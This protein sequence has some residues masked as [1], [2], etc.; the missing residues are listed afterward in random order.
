LYHRLKKIEKI[1]SQI[2]WFFASQFF[3][4]FFVAR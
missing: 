2:K 4:C 3:A 1:A